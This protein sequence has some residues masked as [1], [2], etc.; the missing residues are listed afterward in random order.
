MTRRESLLCLV[1]ALVVWG[2][3]VASHAAS[4]LLAGDTGCEPERLPPDVPLGWTTGRRA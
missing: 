3:A 2:I 4:H 1:T